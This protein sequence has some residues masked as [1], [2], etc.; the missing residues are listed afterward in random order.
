MVG[1]IH[2]S[3]YT[4]PKKTN[5]RKPANVTL[6]SVDHDK[7]LW[8][9]Y[10]IAAEKLLTLEKNTQAIQLWKGQSLELIKYFSRKGSLQDYPGLPENT[11]A[12]LEKVLQFNSHYIQLVDHFLNNGNLTSYSQWPNNS[13]D[14]K[15]LEDIFEKHFAFFIEPPK[16]GKLIFISGSNRQSRMLDYENSTGTNFDDPFATSQRVPTAS[17]VHTLKNLCSYYLLKNPGKQASVSPLLLAD[18][19]T[20]ATVGTTYNAIEQEVTGEHGAYTNKGTPSVA[21]RALKQFCAVDKTKFTEVY[22]LVQAAACQNPNGMKDVEFIDDHHEILQHLQKFFTE[23]PEFIPKNVRL[24]LRQKDMIDT[25][26]IEFKSIEIEGSGPINTHGQDACRFL[27]EANVGDSEKDNALLPYEERSGFFA[28]HLSLFTEIATIT[29]HSSQK[30]ITALAQKIIAQEENHPGFLKH[31][32]PGEPDSHRLVLQSAVFEA[33]DK[34][35]KL[36]ETLTQSN[37]AASQTLTALEQTVLGRNA[38]GAWRSNW[39]SGSAWS[40][41]LARRTDWSEK[42]WSNWRNGT[43]NINDPKNLEAYVGL[44]PWETR[45]LDCSFQRKIEGVPVKMEEN[46]ISE[47]LPP[48]T[49]EV[50]SSFRCSALFPFWFRGQTEDD[51]AAGKAKGNGSILASVYSFCSW[52]TKQDV[53]T[54]IERGKEGCK[55]ANERLNEASAHLIGQRDGLTTRLTQRFIGEAAAP[56]DT[57]NQNR[58]DLAGNSYQLHG[59]APQ[60]TMSLVKNPSDNKFDGNNSQSSNQFTEWLTSE[61]S[62]EN[63]TKV[64]RRLGVLEENWGKLITSQLSDL[65]CTLDQQLTHAL[66]IFEASLSSKEKTENEPNLKSIFAE[67][68]VQL[69]Q[70]VKTQVQEAF[71]QCYQKQ[72]HCLDQKGFSR[73]QT[74]LDKIHQQIPKMVLPVVAANIIAEPKFKKFFEKGSGTRA[75]IK[76]QAP[77]LYAALK[78][79]EKKPT[80]T[81]APALAREDAQRSVGKP[82]SLCNPLTWGNWGNRYRIAPH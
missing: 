71:S 82:F 64:A 63:S 34:R 76:E 10:E 79:E 31:A 55:E 65:Q 29:R 4:T 38:R 28:P 21:E 61:A 62:S 60:I 3:E 35:L 39:L 66:R 53:A 75:A 72:E 67:A 42:G 37:S 17:S 19:Q 52:P 56:T 58:Y 77:Q 11:Q 12:A 23:H 5:A 45:L 69:I 13:I 73:L 46:E 50:T 32:F 7:C 25:P 80:K 1:N 27:I 36:Y 20:S 68:R 57:L 24:C 30:T 81:A 6:R 78:A 59:E 8:L 40:A 33:L 14:R 49:K 47:K 44:W 54:S 51:K 18:V 2:R 70:A 74:K 41:W 15:N 48:E 43:H 16:Q 9:A 26:P 22:L